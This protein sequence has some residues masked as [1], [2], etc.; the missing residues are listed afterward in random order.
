MAKINACA[1]LLLIARLVVAATFLLA[2][3]PKIQ[4][5]L[6]FT[7]SIEAYRIIENGLSA[8]VALTLP[9]LELIIG[10][11]LLTPQLRRA[12]ALCIGILLLLFICLHLSA[13]IRGLNINCGC[14]GAE[15]VEPTLDYLW[16]ILRNGGLLVATAFVFLRDLRN[17]RN[18]SESKETGIS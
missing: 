17:P 9:W 13:W 8:W 7:G 6:T 15:Q 5:P 4:D 10:V 14:F 18:I 1:Y 2:A 12:S 11:G 3:L 16:R